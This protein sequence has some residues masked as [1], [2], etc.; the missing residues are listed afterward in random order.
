MKEPFVTITEFRSGVDE[1]AWCY[2]AM[3]DRRIDYW[4]FN[5]FLDSKKRSALACISEKEKQI[6]ESSPWLEKVDEYKGFILFWEK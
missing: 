4:N 1:N 2:E 3:K 5:G 6:L